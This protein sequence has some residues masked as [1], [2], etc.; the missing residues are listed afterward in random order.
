MLVYPRAPFFAW[1]NQALQES[2]DYPPV[3]P[4]AHESGS[5]FLIEEVDGQEDFEVW[6]AANYEYF[7]ARLLEEWVVDES[8]WPA[9]VNYPMFKD[10]FF[11]VYHSLIIDV[12][13]A[14]L[15]REA[16]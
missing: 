11:V 1:V 8:L 5:L 3:D 10:W 2:E 13:E 9:D 15:L 7:F 14:P 4:F 12:E 16:E 6:L